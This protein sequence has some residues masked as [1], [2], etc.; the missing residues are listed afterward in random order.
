MDFLLAI[1]RFVQR[2]RHQA[3]RNT[4]LIGRQGAPVCRKA[5]EIADKGAWSTENSDPMAELSASR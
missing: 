2:Q 4:E 3:R 5:Y 1:M